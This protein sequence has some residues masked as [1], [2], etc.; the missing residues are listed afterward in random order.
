MNLSERAL[1]TAVESLPG[2]PRVVA[3]GNFATPTTLLSLVDKAL[4]TYRLYIL[5]AQP[6]AFP[7]ATACCTRRPSW[8]RACGAATVCATCRHACPC[9]PSSSAARFRPTRP[10]STPHCLATAPCPWAPRST[11]FPRPSRR[12]DEGADWSSPR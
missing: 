12:Y 5:N 7:P 10:S 9:C 3:S 8:A 11:C 4:G 1:L 6:P 2:A